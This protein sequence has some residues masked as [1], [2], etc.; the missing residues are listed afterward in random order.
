MDKDEDMI[1]A[2]RSPYAKRKFGYAARI[3][4]PLAA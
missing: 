4:L 1:K 2:A 3:I